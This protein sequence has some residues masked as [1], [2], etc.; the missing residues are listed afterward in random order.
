MTK[1]E[2][3]SDPSST[4]NKVGDDEPI[5]IL[6]AQDAT[7][8]MAVVD[9]MNR[10]HRVGASLQKLSEA[11]ALAVSMLAWREQHGAKIPD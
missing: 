6:R 10:A 5:F 4:W 8:A 3:I 7:A 2:E 11:F 9:W 1:K